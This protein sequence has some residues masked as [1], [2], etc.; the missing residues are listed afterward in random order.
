MG[1]AVKTHAQ[2]YVP[3]SIAT[4]LNF[5]VPSTTNESRTIASYGASNCKVLEVFMTIE[6]AIIYFTGCRH[7]TSRLNGSHFTLIKEGVRWRAD[8]ESPL[9][10]ADTKIFDRYMK[11]MMGRLRLSRTEDLGKG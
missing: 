9:E 5:Y 10:K 8:K 7:D 1:A 2:C 4:A 3:D 11:E 6:G